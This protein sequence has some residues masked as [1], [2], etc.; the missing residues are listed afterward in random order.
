MKRILLWTSAVLALGLAAI[1]VLG[2]IAWWRTRPEAPPLPRRTLRLEVLG[3]YALFGADGRR[4]D[5]TYYNAS[6]LVRLDSGSASGTVD[7]VAGMLRDLVALDTLGR[8]SR[9]T[10]GL[11]GPTWTADSLSDTIRVS[12]VNGFSGAEFVLAAPPRG[13][14]T[15]R[16]RAVE[17]WDF[18]PATTRRGAAHAVRIACP[19]PDSVG[20]RAG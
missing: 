14:D 8:P 4:V 10:R 16:G 9:T 18:G 15:L 11:L 20:V 3:C 5:T 6:P 13:G 2:G 17:H 1:A 19:R 12:F 7:S